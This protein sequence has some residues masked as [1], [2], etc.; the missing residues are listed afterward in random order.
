M[1]ILSRRVKETIRIGDNISVTILQI[2]GGQVRVG[3]TAPKGIPVHREEVYNLIREKG[4]QNKC[5]Q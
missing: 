4:E 2:G 3:I 1:L 5:Q